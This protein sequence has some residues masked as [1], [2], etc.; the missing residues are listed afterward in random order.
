MT[1]DVH[2][3]LATEYDSHRIDHQLHDVPPH[4]VYGVHVEGRRAV[5]KRDTGPTGTAAEEGLVTRFV[6]TRTTVPVPEVRHV[7]DDHYVAAWHPDAPDPEADHGVD[8]SWADAAGR[9][10]ATLHEETA[11]LVDGYGRLDPGEDGRTNRAG[12]ERATWHA[13]VLDY[14]RRRHAAVAEY[15]HG[16]TVDAVLEAVRARPDA[17]AGA[18]PAACCHGWASPEHVA[19]RNGEV[20]CVVDFEHALA[21]PGEYDYW[22]TVIPTFDDDTAT[23]RRTFRAAY[24]SVRPLSEGFERRAPYYRLLA[25][26]YYLESLHVQAQHGP[27]ATADRAT[28]LTAAID[29]TL[30]A[31]D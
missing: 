1:R 7:G 22:R 4:E 18:G 31:L 10:I 2:D 15:G 30:D 29:E 24:E 8:E 21:A 28:A 3:A 11:P 13:A 12:G 5:C 27:E 25:L 6:G 9:A 26:V 20:A 19:V 14:L 16:D 23:E 17:F